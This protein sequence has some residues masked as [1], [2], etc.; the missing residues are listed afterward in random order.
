MAAPNP[1]ALEAGH[2]V[3]TAPAVSAAAS[4]IMLSAPGYMCQQQQPHRLLTS[5]E[6]AMRYA[7][8]PSLPLRLPYLGRRFLAIVC[9]LYHKLRC[10]RSAILVD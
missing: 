10:G 1:T 8:P 7:Y 9:A 2:R 6:L 3:V 4:R 5:R